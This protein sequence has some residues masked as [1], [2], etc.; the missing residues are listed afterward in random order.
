MLFEKCNRIEEQIIKIHCL[1]F[2]QILLVLLVQRRDCFLKRP[3]GLVGE[4]LRSQQFVFGAAD[5]FGFLDTLPIAQCRTIIST[6]PE[7][8]VNEALTEYVRRHNQEAIILCI[9]NHHHQAA[10]LYAAGATYVIVPPYLGR[11]YLIELLR[12]YGLNEHG[13]L[14]ERRLHENELRY[15]ENGGN[16]S[17]TFST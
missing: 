15:I 14:T 8:A 17:S 3:I 1:V 7:T 2:P 6:I 16:L 10:S 5:D 12:E 4:L 9:A 13:Y 11:R